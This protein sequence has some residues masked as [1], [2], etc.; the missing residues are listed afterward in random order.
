M[1]RF[2]TTTGAPE[3]YQ[4]GGWTALGGGGGGGAAAATNLLINAGFRINQREYVLGTAT[5]AANQYTLDR[6]RVDTAGQAL[7][8]SNTGNSISATA[9]AGGMSQIVEG[10]NIITG[11]HVLTWQG[12]ATAQV[13]GTNVTTGT[14]FALVGGA[15]ATIRFLNG[16]VLQPKLGQGDTASGYAVTDYGAE[17]L[18]CQRY[19]E[20]VA[21]DG[22]GSAWT[23]GDVVNTP[24]QFK[25]TKRVI[26]T[27][28]AVV[29][30][31]TRTQT[32]SNVTSV[33][34]SNASTMGCTLYIAA[35]NQ[36]GFGLVGYR[37]SVDA[38][39]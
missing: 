13:N 8:L 3:I 25:A 16:T 15:P 10:I 17:L 31:P 14:P 11:N 30:D 36:Y 22:G 12:T 34:V 32:A 18:R 29:V 7:T 5:T 19:F 2:N 6:W 9:P 27:L 21:A 4:A 35:G 20:W 39:L 24:V 38:E 37:A 28:G 23:P 1:L 33:S 26:P